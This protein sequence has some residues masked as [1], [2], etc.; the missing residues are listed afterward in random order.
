MRFFI[1]FLFALILSGCAGLTPRNQSVVFG[2][3]SVPNPIVV[4]PSNEDFSEDVKKIEE[5]SNSIDR[6]ISSIQENYNS[7]QNSL[8]GLNGKLADF[9]TDIGKVLDLNSEINAIKGDL[10]MQNNVLTELKTNIDTNIKSEINGIK[11]DFKSE[12]TGLKTNINSNSNLPLSFMVVFGFVVIAMLVG[13]IMVILQNN[14]QKKE[15]KALREN[16]PIVLP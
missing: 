16:P 5:K 10:M 11:S 14:K 2:A 3:N 1:I 9:K 8:I 6:K 12:I 13:L 4:P 7:V 15:L